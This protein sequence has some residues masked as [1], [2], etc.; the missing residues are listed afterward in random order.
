MSDFKIANPGGDQWGLV[1][2]DGDLVLMDETTELD[3]VVGQRVVYNVM[4]WYGESVYDPTKGVPHLE[5]LGSL[6]GAEGIAGIYALVIQET[7]GVDE[8]VDFAYTAP[9]VDTDFELR[10]SPVIRVGSSAQTLGLVIGG[11]FPS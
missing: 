5:I 11:G 6:D 2:E 3:A 9:S 1:V 10:V 7:P 4:T 8:I